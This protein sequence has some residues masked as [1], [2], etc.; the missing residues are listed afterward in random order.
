MLIRGLNSETQMVQKLRAGY[1]FRAK[2]A[3]V[4][5][6]LL[7]INYGHTMIVAPCAQSCQS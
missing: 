7:A 5:G 4:G 6:F 2:G 3:K 1:G